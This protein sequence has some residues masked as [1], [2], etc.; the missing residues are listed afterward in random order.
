MNSDNI[1]NA[2]SDLRA[3][4]N[5]HNY[6]YHTCD[7][8]QITDSDYDALFKELQELEQLY[9]E[10]ITIDSPTQ[11]VG[12]ESLQSFTKVRH[13]VPMLSLNN[14]FFEQDWQAFYQRAQ[15]ALGLQDLTFTCEPKLDGL[16]V[17][18][19]YEH[20]K[21]VKAATR[22]DGYLG[23]DVTNNIRTI[24]SLPLRL[25]IAKPPQ[26]L[27]V[28]A[29]VYMPHA[30]FATLN[31]LCLAE[32]E[33][34]FAN[35][36]NAAAGSLRQLDARI[37]STRP[38]ALCCYGI[39]ACEGSELPDSHS[40]RL[41][42]LKTLG[43]P[44]SV[45]NK[46]AHGTTACLDYYAKILA[47]RSALPF[48]IDGV[49]YK[50]DSTLLQQELGFIARA[51]RFAIAYK[52]PAIE[53]KTQLV[54]VDFQVGRSGAITPV[55][56]L[57]PVN[58]A[59]V[60]VSNATLHNMDEIARKGIYIGATVIVRR[61]GDVIPEVVGVADATDPS[62]DQPNHAQPNHAQPNHAQPSRAQPS[63]ARKQAEQFDVS[64]QFDGAI[65]H[66]PEICPSCQTK[67]IH[68]KV[69]LRC[70]ATLTCP[71][72]L[73]RSIWHFA[74]RKGLAIAG[75][76]DSIIELL[77]DSKIVA[78]IADLYTLDVHT[79]LTLPRFAELSANKIIA[80]INASKNTSFAHFIYA[81]G[82]P[83]VGEAASRTLA[84]HYQGDMNSLIACKFEDLLSL[85][86]IGT[87]VA[88]SI[89][90]FFALEYNRILIA[91]LLSSGINWPQVTIS[92]ASYNIF[93]GKTVVI[94][95]S[96]AKYSRENLKEILLQVKAKV[97]NSVSGKTDYLLCGD[98]PGSKLVRA[99]ELGVM[100]LYEDDLLH[101]LE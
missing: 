34:V 42:L 49:V 27:E 63:R 54:A 69:A 52:F 50:I 17:S 97:A 48:D 93:T 70:P 36:R 79:L 84:D 10:L 2:V 45:Y 91:K 14:V 58:V 78:S 96:F 101:Y 44:V 30:G 77:V 55:A 4:I 100:V 38:L 23:E 31:A 88:N 43:L 47:Q 98:D 22:G 28:R 66:P 18:L 90:T 60:V 53:A 37:T 41:A 29:E 32:G 65:I 62:R 75:L 57:A 95:G 7:N 92:D 51:P 12:G 85:Q 39:A 83:E 86:D 80:S 74:S 3:K 59:G 33:K 99:Q 64:E 11:R 16:A 6:Y 26:F 5:L 15:E 19:I 9:P 24:K 56:R 40:A 13:Q 67:L 94:T 25:L 76:G 71:A 82:I 61:A 87:I 1:R 21:L 81:L 73:K 46:V 89:I 72:Q 35:P 8:P 68:E 20:G